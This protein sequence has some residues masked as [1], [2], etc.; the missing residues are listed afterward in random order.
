MNTTTSKRAVVRNMINNSTEVRNGRGYLLSTIANRA[1]KATGRA[2]NKS[3]VVRS[4]RGMCREGQ[5]NYYM[6]GERVF[7]WAK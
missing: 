1:S 3:D 2:I 6:N 7:G 4:L 5:I